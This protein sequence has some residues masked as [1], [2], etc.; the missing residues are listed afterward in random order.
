MKRTIAFT[1]AVVMLTAVFSLCLPCLRF[2]N[3]PFD[4]FDEERQESIASS[5][6]TALN[7]S[8][9]GNA[10]TEKGYIVRFKDSVSLNN[11]YDCVQN[12]G[13]KLL[14]ESKKRI[15]K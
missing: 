3:N 12:Y 4:Y 7:G 8:S 1:L 5:I 14:A 9:S 15:F 11:V 6:D 2:E 10:I 13:F